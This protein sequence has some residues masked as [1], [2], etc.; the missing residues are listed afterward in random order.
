[1]GDT[2]GS[3]IGSAVVFSHNMG[4]VVFAPEGNNTA[5]RRAHT[6]DL[7][8]KWV[9]YNLEFAIKSNTNVNG[10][11]SAHYMDIF[12][13]HASF[14]VHNELHYADGWIRQG[15]IEF[16]GS[17]VHFHCDAPTYDRCSDSLRSPQVGGS[18][19][20]SFLEFR[21]SSAHTYSYD[22]GAR[23][24][25]VFVV[26]NSNGVSTTDTGPFSVMAVDIKQG[27]F[28]AP[29]SSR[30]SISEDVS[31]GSIG[32]P[33]GGFVLAP[34]A[35]FDPNGSEIYFQLLIQSF[36][37]RRVAAI[38]GSGVSFDDLTI[39]GIGDSNNSADGNEDVHVALANNI[40]VTVTNDLKIENGR[41]T[42]NYSQTVYVGGNYYREC[43]EFIPNHRCADRD[44]AI[45]YEFTGPGKELHFETGA[46]EQVGSA[47]YYIN[48]GAGQ[49]IT[50]KGPFRLND[51]SS[52]IALQSGNLHLESS[53]RILV[54]GDLR[55]VGGS[56]T[57]DSGGYILYAGSLMGVP[58]AGDDSSCYGSVPVDP[59][60]SSISWNDFSG[61]SP[62]QTFS[63]IN[64]AIQISIE[65]I[66]HPDN[67][68][69]PT[70]SR[71]SWSTRWQNLSVGTANQWILN[72]Q[73]LWFR[74]TGQS[75][76]RAQIT[77]RNLSDGNSVLDS[78]LATVP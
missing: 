36:D 40:D 39:N 30:L 66:L 4:T 74:I 18:W 23:S 7:N 63:D 44:S 14:E 24:P 17:N 54:E 28:A 64:P 71:R 8:Q 58:G 29:A 2:R 1:M 42:G 78:F 22:Q 41:L 34:G 51:S 61:T 60:P 9:L 33:T 56:I 69:T 55:Y 72:N 13:T 53:A 46:H 10:R 76:D 77:V 31:V 21:G 37:N 6:I 35:T 43:E 27:S 62:V 45:R 50:A 59:T 75:G 16:Y 65:V 67:I 12:G 3:T 52:Y 20:F 15:T 47:R 38:M 73:A 19:Y 25:S 68:G 5:N 70:V 48:P 49:T 57:C 26:E 32:R 11:T